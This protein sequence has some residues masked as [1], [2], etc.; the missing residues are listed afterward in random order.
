MFQTI[1]TIP[2]GIGASFRYFKAKGLTKVALLT[3]NDEPGN[4]A[5]AGAEK[6]AASSGV[7]LVTRQVFDPQAQNLAGQ[8][9]SIAGAHP[10]AVLA[11]TA[12]PQLITALRALQAAGVKVPVMLNYASMSTALLSKAGSQA[13]ANIL[14]FASRAFVADGIQ[15]AA[16]KQRVQAFN[17]RFD[18]QYHQTPD[19]TAYDA[20]DTVFVIGAAAKDSTDPKAIRAA[21]EN[22]QPLAGLLFPSY[23]YSAGDHVGISGADVFDIL[24]W[25]PD[26]KT[27][28]LAK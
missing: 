23:K 16:W 25:L 4:L 14:F 11:W 2:D 27:W 9:E 13:T 21:L 19:L 6:L 18:A 12:G 26:Q 20:G 22:G 7:T 3:S 17:T 1:P 28:E 24:K 5:K 8:A 10:D 15:D